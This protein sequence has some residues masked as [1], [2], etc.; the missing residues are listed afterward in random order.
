MAPKRS[1]RS[2]EK[3]PRKTLGDIIDA[4]PFRKL[5]KSPVLNV[6]ALPADTLPDLDPPAYCEKEATGSSPA[7]DQSFIRNDRRKPRSRR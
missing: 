3:P 4:L 5:G 7:A 2:S 1:T 6:G